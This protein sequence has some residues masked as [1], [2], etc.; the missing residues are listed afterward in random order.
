MSVSGT[1]IIWHCTVDQ[2]CT[3]G[4]SDAHSRRVTP[5]AW[6]AGAE[7]SLAPDDPAAGR[8]VPPPAEGGCTRVESGVETAALAPA[9]AE[10]ARRRHP[11]VLC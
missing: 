1:V 9:R 8:A 10:A 3:A 11:P 6:P 2:L 5:P 4:S 7:I